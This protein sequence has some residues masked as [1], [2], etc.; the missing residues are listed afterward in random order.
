V[1]C[2]EGKTLS[3]ISSSIPQSYVTVSRAITALEEVGLGFSDRFGK[4]K[5]FHFKFIGKEL[6]EK[7]Q[8]YLVS[9]VLTVRYFDAFDGSGIIGG[10]NA[11]A[12]Y[13][14]LNPEEMQTLVLDRNLVPGDNSLEDGRYRI[15]VWKYPPIGGGPWV[16]KL[17]LALS[18]QE[19]KDERVQKEIELM[20]NAIW[21][22]E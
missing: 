18:L 3:E 4:I 8:P 13:S 22:T 7:A 5:V 9:P 15:E 21:S 16:D 20:I 19:N 1:E 12:H 2:L 11:L 14:H 10:I 17:S 6:W